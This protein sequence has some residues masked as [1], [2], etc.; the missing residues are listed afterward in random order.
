MIRRYALYDGKFQVLTQDS[1]THIRPD[2]A[3]SFYW[4]Q[5]TRPD[6]GELQALLELYNVPEDYITAALDVSEVP[7]TEQIDDSP[8]LFLFS[9]PIKHDRGKFA[10]RPLS[11]IV[12]P[13]E[14]ITVSSDA[15]AFMDRVEA[16]YRGIGGDEELQNFVANVAWAI[17]SHFVEDVRELN[18]MIDGIEKEVRIAD[19]PKIFM[20]MIDIQKSLIRFDMATQENDPVIEA[21]FQSESFTT[22]TRA[23]DLLRDLQIENYQ[24]RCMIEEASTIMESL[25]DLYSNLIAFN[26]NVAMKVLTSITIVLTVPTIIGGLWGMNVDLPIDHTPYAFWILI[27]LCAAVSYGLIK[28]FNRKGYL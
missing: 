26:L 15:P 4:T 23:L 14:V 8:A 11:V 6:D 12:L 9:Y 7:R 5:V 2:D 18:R 17:C 24:A 1:Q 19:K 28:Y 16:T 25:S 13:G 21:L 27:L 22:S 10:T 20:Q 3:A